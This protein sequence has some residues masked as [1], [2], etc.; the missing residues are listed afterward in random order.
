MPVS[1]QNYHQFLVNQG[2]MAITSTW[3]L[4][5]DLSFILV[6][7][8]FWQVKVTLLI[9]RLLSQ[10]VKAKQQSFRSR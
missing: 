7:D 2:S 6:V 1:S 9:A 3:L 8:N 4:P 10:R 5:Q